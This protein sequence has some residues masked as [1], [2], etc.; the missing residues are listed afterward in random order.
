MTIRQS[1]IAQAAIGAALAVHSFSVARTLPSRVPI[2]WDISGKV[3]AYGSPAFALWFGPGMMLF[4]ILMTW[5]LP[6]ISPKQFTI[7]RFENTYATVTF[8]VALLFA[9]LHFIILGATA[10]KNFDMGRVVMAAL[11]V[12]FALIGNLMGKVRRNFYMGI[13]TPWTLASEKVWDATHRRAG[14]IWFF[15]GLLVAVLALIGVPMLVTLPIFL[16]ITL[17]PVVQSYLLDRKLE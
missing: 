16:V 2:H 4:M 8:I 7:D 17:I 5:G 11:G 10:G 13:R 6:K 1:L 14:V 9:V 3:D 15:G 12:F